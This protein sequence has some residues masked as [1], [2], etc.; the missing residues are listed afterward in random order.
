MLEL[1]LFG[2]TLE[3]KLFMSDVL[4]GLFEEFAGVRDGIASAESTLETL[5][6]SRSNLAQAIHTES[7]GEQFE[8]S[9][10]CTYRAVKGKETK[11][12]RTTYMLREVNAK[13]DI[14]AALAASNAEVASLREE[15]ARAQA[16]QAHAE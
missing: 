2:K 5:K 3:G 12:G 8:G 16:S 10:G 4:D 13:G 1:F 15:L 11:E 6:V 14:K 7:K 9:D